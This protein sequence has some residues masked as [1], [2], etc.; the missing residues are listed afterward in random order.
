MN[1]EVDYTYTDKSTGR[2]I[3]FTPSR[4]EVVVRFQQRATEET[5]NEILQAT[6]LS[7]VSQ[8]FDLDRGL[9]VFAVSPDQGVEATIRL[10]EERREIAN[11]LPAVIDEDGRTRYFVPGEFTVQFNDAISKQQAERLIREH[12]SRV[13][14]EQRTPGYYTLQ[15][16]EGRRLFEVIREFSDI[17]DVQF[18]EPSEVSFNDLLFIPDD[19]FFPLQWGLNNT[20][21]P[22][23]GV[24]GIAGS[25]IGMTTAW[26]VVRGDP[27]V[28]VAVIDTGADLDHP[29]LQAN[30][31]PRGGE[32]WNFAETNPVPEDEGVILPPL[33][34]GEPNRVLDKGHGTHVSGIVAA[35]D[36]AVGVVGV[37]PGCRIMPLR[38]PLAAGT[39]PAVLAPRADAI[40][41]VAQQATANPHRRYVINCSWKVNGDNAGVRTAIQNAVSSNVVVVAAAGNSRSNI[42]D[43]PAAYPEV[44]AVG[45]LDKFGRKWDDTIFGTNFGADLDVCAPGKDIL[46]TFADNTHA[47]ESGTSMATP[48]VAGLA[49]LI[50]SGDPTLTNLEVRQRIEST[51]DSLDATHPGFIG[52]LGRGRINAARAVIPRRRLSLDPDRL[53]FGIVHIEFPEEQAFSVRNIGVDPV[54]VSFSPSQSV[55][56][57]NAPNGVV[58]PGGTVSVVVRCAPDGR[59][60]FQAQVVVSSNA[61]GSPHLVLLRAVG[62][63]PFD[64]PRP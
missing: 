39:Q 25:D 53:D 23:L 27:E 42:V 37:A 62:F 18:A 40:N 29:D 13:L 22:V 56:S 35:V 21:Q 55:F 10:L 19:P 52:Q 26:D 1:T 11:A 49:A 6:P 20:G 51:C 43:F 30:I 4:G 41:Y 58:P 46:S 64:P 16:P 3:T 2:Q 12:G 50:W 59:G 36:N 14:V 60:T 28:I 24:T 48:H 38:I 8:G 9:A 31:L 5:L 32:D 34:P 47:F 17:D 45:A 54:N 44:M 61:F 33:Q 57:W 63:D 15:I 7:S